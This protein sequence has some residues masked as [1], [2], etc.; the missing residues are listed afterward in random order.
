MKYWLSLFGGLGLGLDC[1]TG[2]R[3]SVALKA[4]HNTY[5]T[6]SR[7]AI[8][9]RYQDSTQFQQ[10]FLPASVRA[11][12]VPA[13]NQLIPRLRW[14]NRSGDKDLHSDS[15]QD[16]SLYR[17]STSGGKARMEVPWQQHRNN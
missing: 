14:D 15:Q 5:I 17:H 4:S 9:I 1:D 11:P 8:M 7:Q 12:Q 13:L 2:L 3:E 16:I 10:P 6:N